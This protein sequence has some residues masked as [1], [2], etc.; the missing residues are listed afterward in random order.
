MKKNLVIIKN[1][2]QEIESLAMDLGINDIFRNKKFIEVLAAYML[3]HRPNVEPQGPDAY[4]M[5][6]GIEYPTEYKSAGVGGTF[7]FHWLSN[8]KMDKIKICKNVYFIV[9][10]GVSILE[11]YRV[12]TEKIV[13]RIEEKASGS[14]SPK[15]CKAFSLK[16]LIDLGAKKLK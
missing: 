3:G 1:K 7:Q 9:R 6:G 2:L 8:N 15:G 5:I 4:E 13:S 12:A 16:N 14:K 10:S 11:I